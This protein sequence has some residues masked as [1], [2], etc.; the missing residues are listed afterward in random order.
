MKKFILDDLGVWKK[1]ILVHFY[2]G[3]IFKIFLV[4]W[5]E[6]YFKSTNT[7]RFTMDL[8][9]L[10]QENITLDSYYI[11]AFKNFKHENSLFDCLPWKSQ[12]ISKGIFFSRN[13]KKNPRCSFWKKKNQFLLFFKSH[14]YQ[15]ILTYMLS[16][17]TQL[18]W[19]LWLTSLYIR[20][21]L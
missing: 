7:K 17:I 13:S 2:F 15:V 6:K 20:L 12:K 1:F 3:T 8:K 5:L 11:L 19:F 14:M 18:F 10:R 9:N 21:H 4:Q 16:F